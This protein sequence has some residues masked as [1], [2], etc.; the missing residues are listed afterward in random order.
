[1]DA[2]MLPELP[3]QIPLDQDIASVTAP[4]H[5][6][7][8]N[9]CRATDGACDTRKCHGAIHCPLPGHFQ[10]PARQWDSACLHA[11]EGP[12]AG[13]MPSS[14]PAKTPSP[15]KPT[16]PERSPETMPSAHQ[17]ALAAPSGDDGAATTAEAAQRPTLSWFA[18]KPLPG[19]GCDFRKTSGSATHS[20][21][22]PDYA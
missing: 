12:S 1:M 11:R 5:G 8:A 18:N 15:G 9:R 22:L 20:K 19:S 17:G 14:H 16:A 7:Q 10:C 4:S 21:R 2:P 3:D 13:L 6:L